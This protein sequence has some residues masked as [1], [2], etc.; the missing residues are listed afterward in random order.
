[1]KTRAAVAFEAKKLHAGELGEESEAPLNDPVD[2][3][4]FDGRGEPLY[5]EKHRL[6]GTVTEITVTVEGEP[7][8]AGI[9]PYHKLIDRHPD[10]NEVNVT[11]EAG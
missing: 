2:L 1:M 8:T 5:L 7:A 6:D 11:I 9:D 3:G 10:D 4:I